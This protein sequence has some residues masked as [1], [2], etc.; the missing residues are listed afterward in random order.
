MR[1]ASRVWRYA[2][3][4]S[5]LAMFAVAKSGGMRSSL[6]AARDVGHIDQS[7]TAWHMGMA[8]EFDAS[9]LA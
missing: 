4:P 6:V 7:A 5:S 1:A 3:S 8:R 2:I 9:A